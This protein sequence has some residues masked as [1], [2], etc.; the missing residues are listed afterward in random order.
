MP[1]TRGTMSRT[2][3]TIIAVIEEAA[4]VAGVVEVD[5]RTK[6]VVAGVE[7]AITATSSNII[8]RRSKIHR[9]K[10]VTII[11]K[12]I[13]NPE[14]TTNR[15]RGLHKKSNLSTTDL[16]LNSISQHT[17]NNHL[18]RI[19]SHNSN[20]TRI[21]TKITTKNSTIKN[22]DTIRTTTNNNIRMIIMDMRGSVISEIM[23]MNTETL[24]DIKTII[25][26]FPNTKVDRFHTNLIVKARNNTIV[27][28]KLMLLQ[29]NSAKIK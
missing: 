20:S 19:L 9:K 1:V 10:A 14:I 11:I 26:K 8:K 5:I 22:K 18:I 6:E 23:E 2:T 24:M 17:T 15:K 4:K 25:W 21:N 16:N 13:T 7:K 27:S 28:S 12:K 29:K 3:Q